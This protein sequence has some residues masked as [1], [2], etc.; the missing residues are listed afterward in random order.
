[1]ALFDEVTNEYNE[2]GVDNLYM[3][4]KFCIDGYTHPKKIK[5]HGV[6][7]KSGRGLPS[8][9]MQQEMQNKAEQE[10]FRGTVLV[11][12]LVGDSKCPSLIAVSVYDNK[13]V[14]FIYMKSESIKWE[15]KSKPV[16]N[17]SIGQM[18]I[19]KFLRLNINGDYNYSMGGADIAD[20]IHGSYRF[21]N[22]LRN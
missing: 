21:D 4:T 22:W 6:T 10:K 17:R 19:M 14:H 2:C 3:Y 16:Y 9:I 7:R 1:M 20:Q 8:T 15:E 5:L 18:S 11:A 12:E 13:T